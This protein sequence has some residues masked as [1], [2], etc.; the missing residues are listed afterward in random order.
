MALL[1]QLTGVAVGV[2][3]RDGAAGQEAV[4]VGDAVGCQPPEGKLKLLD[5]DAGAQPGDKVG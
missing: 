5:V 2:F 1:A 3:Q 4:A